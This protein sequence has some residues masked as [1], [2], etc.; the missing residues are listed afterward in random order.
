M[1]QSLGDR[2]QKRKIMEEAW[3]GKV[4]RRQKLRKM[5][6]ERKRSRALIRMSHEGDKK[7]KEET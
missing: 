7:R 4:T 3:K 2:K 1:D 5:A 6:T